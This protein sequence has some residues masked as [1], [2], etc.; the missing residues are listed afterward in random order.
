M[1]YCCDAFSGMAAD[2]GMS[3]FSI[4]CVY[5]NGQ[6]T[7][8]IYFRAVPAGERVALSGM[9]LKS[10]AGKQTRLIL[11]SRTRLLFCPWCGVNLDKFYKKK[12][13]VFPPAKGL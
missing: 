4:E 5:L 2:V 1:D 12:W 13:P 8:M 10:V 7:V 9:D 3:G 11:A 6:P